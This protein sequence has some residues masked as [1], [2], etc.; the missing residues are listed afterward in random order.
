MTNTDAITM[1]SLPVVE[2]YQAP[3]EFRLLLMAAFVFSS[4]AGAV[5]SITVLVSNFSE[6]FS[7]VLFALDILCAIVMLNV[8]RVA[9]RNGHAVQLWFICLG[10]FAIGLLTALLLFSS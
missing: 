2:F 8:C 5:I 9:V 3:S 6:P 4:S 10:A 7:P 1:D